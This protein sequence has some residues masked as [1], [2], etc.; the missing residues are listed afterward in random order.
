MVKIDSPDAWFPRRWQMVCMLVSGVAIAYTLRVNISVA[1]VRMES[2]LG[3][4]ETFKGLVFSSF[5][6]GYAMGQI[7]SAFMTHWYGAKYLFGYSILLGSFFTLLFPVIIKYSFVA[8]LF[9]R[10]LTG[11]AA[12]ATFP[13]LYYFYKSWIPLQEKTVMVSAI[14]SGVYLV[15][16][17]VTVSAV[18]FLDLRFVAVGRD[19]LLLCKWSPRGYSFCILWI[20]YWRVAVLLLVFRRYWYE[21]WHAVQQTN[22]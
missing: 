17:A 7:P 19:H 21:A 18:S 22:I 15:S 20:R 16:A 6:V 1:A 3:W 9:W 2:S 4:D 11:L 10:V 12:S 8:G 13:S 5:Y 14:M